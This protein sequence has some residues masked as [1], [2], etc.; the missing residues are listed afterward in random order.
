MSD[1]RVFKTCARCS[2]FGE[3]EEH[4]TPHL[5]TEVNPFCY[6]CDIGQDEVEYVPIDEEIPF[7]IVDDA[8]S[9]YF[10]VD[11]VEF[12]D[13]GE[14]DGVYADMERALET[15]LPMIKEA[16]IAE[17]WLIPQVAPFT[18]EEMKFIRDWAAQQ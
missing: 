17:G 2:R 5:H 6:R 12:L 9:A 15:A 3:C 16:L 1:V 18:A 7:E 8:L 4:Y 14:Y 13:T 11:T 10:G